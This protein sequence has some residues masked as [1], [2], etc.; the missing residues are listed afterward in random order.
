MKDPNVIDPTTVIVVASVQVALPATLQR[1]KDCARSLR[2]HRRESARE[3][4]VLAAEQNW[5]AAELA[6]RQGLDADLLP[7]VR[8]E[9]P[10]DWTGWTAEL[11]VAVEL[12]GH[13]VIVALFRAPFPERSC[14]TWHRA[15]WPEDTHCS[16]PPG[17]W[18][19]ITPDGDYCQVDGL[20]EALLLAEGGEQEKVDGPSI[21]F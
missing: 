20:G 17:W 5:R 4:A 10:R 15:R 13:G 16:L 11:A 12:P 14:Y 21:P 6:V 9:R 1:L 2:D 3:E 18:R 19:T 7:F 8:L